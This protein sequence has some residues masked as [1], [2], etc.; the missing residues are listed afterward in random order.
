[1]VVEQA[2]PGVPVVPSQSPNWPGYALDGTSLNGAQGTFNVPNLSATAGTSVASKWVGVDGNTNSF[3]IQTGVT[4]LYDPTT[5]SVLAYAWW[6]ILPAPNTPILT[7]TVSPGD[8]I[9]A[10]VQQVAGTTWGISVVDTGQSFTSDQYYAGPETSAEWIFEAPSLNGSVQQLGVYSPSVTFSSLA[11]DGNQV[12]FDRL[13]MVDNI[14]A[15]V[16]SPLS[17]DANGFTGA[18]GPN[19]PPAP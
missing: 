14:G 1:V 7:M 3:L 2:N 17:L 19:P 10:T 5:N 15:V 18:C 13:F 9:T 6:E 12:Q 16:S 11:V 4:E 8:S